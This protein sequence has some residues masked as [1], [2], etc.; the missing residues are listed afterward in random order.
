MTDWE[1]LGGDF[2]ADPV[3]VAFSP[4]GKTLVSGSF[5]RTVRLWD[6]ATGETCATLKGHE[7]IVYAVAFSPDGKTLASKASGS[8]ASGS[9][10]HR[11]PR[12]RQGIGVR[13]I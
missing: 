11:G 7:G 3:A 13:P 4:N 2:T 5:D 12:H 6:A 1:S 10:R 8:K 9:P